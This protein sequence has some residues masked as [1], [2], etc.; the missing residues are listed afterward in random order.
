M[1]KFK[2]GDKVTHKIMGTIVEVIE[3]EPLDEECFCGR[4]IFQPYNLEELFIPYNDYII[5]N[6]EICNQSKSAQ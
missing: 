2:V 3:G 4:L 1:E 6:Y 5:N